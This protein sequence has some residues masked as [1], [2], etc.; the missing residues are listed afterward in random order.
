M[1]SIGLWQS[2]VLGIVEGLTE[3]LPISSTGHL[4]ITGDLLGMVGE[5]AKLFE[6]VIQLGAILAVVWAYKEK[7]ISLC[8][9]VARRDQQAWRFGMSLAAAFM[10]AA[11]VGVLFHKA[12]KHYLF[13]P[14]T[15]AGALVAGGIAILIIERMR[16]ANRITDMEAAPVKTGWW[17]G[18]AQVFALFPGV[19]RSGAT[20]MGG[21]LAGMSRTA[22]TEFSFFLAIPTMFAATIFD[23][24]GALKI[25]SASDLVSLSVGF[26]T[27]FISALWV[28]RWLIRFVSTNSFRVFAWYRIVFGVLLLIFYLKKG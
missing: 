24:S 26:V 28:V 23:L 20:I 15:V 4:I 22:A 13:G 10:P 17:V 6:V 18:V 16:H 21:L 14:I 3:F 9:R 1:D 19:S 25:M 8:G 27:A 11:V 7:V 12:I 5:K 2:V